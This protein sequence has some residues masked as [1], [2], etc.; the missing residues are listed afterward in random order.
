[1]RRLSGG[2]RQAVAIARAL[3]SAH[4]L[5]MF[6]EPT[7]ALGVNQARATLE[8]IRRVATRGVAVLIVSHNFDEIFAV[9]HRIVVLRQGQITFDRA[10]AAA[11][12]EILAAAMMGLSI[13][14]PD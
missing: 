3:T 10:A 13:S 9:A 14:Q 5:I 2:Q 12:R 7:A 4:R 8:I 6:D 1:M 11:S